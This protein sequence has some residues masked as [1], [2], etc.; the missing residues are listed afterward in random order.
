MLI[1]T[2]NQFPNKYC[3]STR[4]YVSDN[5]KS[6]NTK[7]TQTKPDTLEMDSNTCTTK[8]RWNESEYSRKIDSYVSDQQEK[9]F[10]VKEYIFN[11][12]K[13]N[14]FNKNPE[15]YMSTWKFERGHTEEFRMTEDTAFEVIKRMLKDKT[16]P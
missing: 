1:R 9:I 6:T 13:S 3:V 4:S 8:N 2:M 5:N 12:I 15:K 11:I 7:T 14:D 16:L 10:K